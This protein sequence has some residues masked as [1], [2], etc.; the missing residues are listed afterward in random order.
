MTLISGNKLSSI[1]VKHQGRRRDLIRNP[2]YLFLINLIS[3]LAAGGPTTVNLV[4][5]FVLDQVKR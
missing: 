5:N 4:G 3:T 2:N 1:R